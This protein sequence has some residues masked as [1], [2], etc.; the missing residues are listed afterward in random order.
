MA[1]P[2][3]SHFPVFA[4][5]FIVSHST[6]YRLGESGEEFQREI[7]V[8]S[9]MKRTIP[10]AFW[11]NGFAGGWVCLERCDRRRGRRSLGVISEPKDDISTWIARFAPR[12][13]FPT[14]LCLG[15]H[16]L[17]ALLRTVT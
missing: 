16:V 4:R 8:F 7:T 15:T 13:S 6:K 1:M 5:A 3:C 14:K 12:A 17:K 11:L 2:A 9:W 10:Q